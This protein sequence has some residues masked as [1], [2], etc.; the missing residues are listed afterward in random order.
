V[1]RG[2][3]ADLYVLVDESG[4]PAFRAPQPGMPPD[5][6][7]MAAVGIR[8][9]DR[10]LLRHLLPKKVNG[11]P[12][13]STDRRLTDELA[14]TF[15]SKLL[16]S[17]ASISI[18][19][20]DPSHPETIQIA[21]DAVASA[22]AWRKRDGIPQTSARS[23]AHVLLGCDAVFNAFDMECKSRGYRIASV[24]IVFDEY[25]FSDE[26]CSLIRSRILQV[27]KQNNLEIK[28]MLW[29]SDKYEPLLA[30]PDII[31]GVAYREYCSDSRPKSWGLLRAAFES[32]RISI[33]NG[34]EFKSLPPRRKE[35][36][37]GAG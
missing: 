8:Q 12:R 26:E 33:Q 13:K 18:V 10:L 4:T 30:A 2:G 27:G 29:L 5:A 37:G 11:R 6:F 28:E 16:Q 22:N 25:G 32:K 31:A 35:A 9:R 15:I 24:D 36:A 3:D 19:T 7:V 17:E 34:R 20:L 1:S 21:E 14:A 23:L